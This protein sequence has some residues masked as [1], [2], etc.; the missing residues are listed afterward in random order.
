MINNLIQKLQRFSSV[1]IFNKPLPEKDL[2]EFQR[3]IGSE[4]P[5][6]YATMLR[7]FDG[8]ELFVPGTIM[9]GVNKFKKNDALSEVNDGVYRDKFSI[10][11]TYLII[12][13]LNYGDLLCIDLKNRNE[14][15][16]W[17]HEQDEEFCRWNNFEDWLEETIYDYLEYEGG[18]KK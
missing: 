13:K 1:M 8:G 9:Y 2:S 18:D 14:L 3:V 5:S 10:P 4:L 11:Q 12:G 7:C 16:Q 17:D 15:I 6:S